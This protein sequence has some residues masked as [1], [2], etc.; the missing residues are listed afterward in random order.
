MQN[1]NDR[2]EALLNR[3]AFQMERRSQMLEAST[4]M[5]Q[6]GLARAHAIKQEQAAMSATLDRMEESHD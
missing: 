3:M 4:A 2:A 6:T 5:L 1:D